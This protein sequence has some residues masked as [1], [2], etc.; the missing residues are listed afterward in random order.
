MRRT[1]FFIFLSLFIFNLGIFSQE[2]KDADLA[3]FWYPSDKEEL[4]ILLRN[5]LN[6]AQPEKVEGKILGLISPHAGYLYS[7]L[8]AA[9]GYKLIKERANQIKTVIVIG[10]NHRYPHRGIAVADFDYY[11]TPLGRVKVDKDIV[12]QLIAQNEN[13]YSLKEA[14]HNENSSEMQI[15]FLQVVLKDFKLVIIHL[16]KQTWENCEIL[17]SALLEVLKE[18]KDFLLVA[19]T[20]MSHYL[21]YEQAEKLDFSTISEIEKFNPFSLYT[22]SVMNGNRMC[23][24]GAVCSFLLVLKKLG[25]NKVEILHYANSGD[26]TGDKERVVGYLSAVVVKEDSTPQEDIK[27]KEEDMELTKEDKRTLLEIARKTLESYLPQRK[28]PEFGEVSS[29]LKEVQG[30][31]V[32]L[33]KKGQLRGCIGSITGREPLY[34]TVR[35]MA[36][37]AATADPRFPPVKY[38]ELKDIDI[39]ISVLSPLKKVDSSEEIILGK[40]GV[41][42][43]KGFR[44]GVFLPQVAEET[45]W[46]KGE[47]LS[48]LCAHKAGLPFDCWK[49]K[50]T[51]LYVFTACVFSEEEF[52]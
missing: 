46:S 2:V 5:F 33:K 26:I 39:E 1:I 52:K 9:F 4:R 8:V 24:Y 47:F 20:D 45:G 12:N 27:D 41:I 19:S 44:Q 11:Q 51:E 16:G 32:T 10:F 29:R 28:I 48:Y 34:L 43:K 3:G 36:I 14:F 6:S 18:R 13:I 17:A 37:E 23:G 49:D 40:H 42:V 30:A 35:D 15:P 21:P 50:D 38:E 31:F 7:G 22:S 25:A